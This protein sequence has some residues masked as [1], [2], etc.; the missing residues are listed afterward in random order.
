M[1]ATSNTTT[2][3]I[4]PEVERT[5]W[6]GIDIALDLLEQ[7][8]EANE[9]DYEDDE[10]TPMGPTLAEIRDMKDAASDLVVALQGVK[11]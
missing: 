11:R 6:R 2:L 9:A 3:R 10:E 4:N 7:W 5:G 8:F 1:S